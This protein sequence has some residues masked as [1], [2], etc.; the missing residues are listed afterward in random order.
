VAT[1]NGNG[2]G[3]QVDLLLQVVQR[4]D[5][6]DA[7]FDRLETRFDR[8]ETRFDRMSEQLTETNETLH[9]IA[10]TLAKSVETYNARFEHQDRRISKLEKS[11]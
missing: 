8:L 10:A 2:S 4:L 3:P 1:G 7:R 6:V 5:K 11:G 9:L